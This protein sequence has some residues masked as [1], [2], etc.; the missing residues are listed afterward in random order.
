MANETI[1]SL[2]EVARADWGGTAAPRPHTRVTHT[3]IEVHHDVF[4]ATMAADDHCRK[5]D[6][7]HRGEGKN[8]A[9]YNLGLARDGRLYELRG[10][11]NQSQRTALTVVLFGDYENDVSMTAEQVRTLGRLRALLPEPIDWHKQRHQL[12]GE[13]KASACPGRNAIKVLRDIAADPL[14]LLEEDDM[15]KLYRRPDNSVW[16]TDGITRSRVPSDDVAKYLERAGM[17]WLSPKENNSIV[18]DDVHDS[19]RDVTP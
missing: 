3:H 1:R 12:T 5:I 10:V 19:L 8:G 17:Q 15:A 4:P 7:L 18:Q 11:G 14:P 6:E 2:V 16:R 13:G 9:F